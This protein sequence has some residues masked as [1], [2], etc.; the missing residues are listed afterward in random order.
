MD[1]QYPPAEATARSE[2]RLSTTS[3]MI[4]GEALPTSG[5]G[6]REA[7]AW[8]CLWRP[9]ER[10]LNGLGQL[11][12]RQKRRVELRMEGGAATVSAHTSIWGRERL[13]AEFVCPMSSLKAARLDQGQDARQAAFGVAAFA[14]GTFAG[15]WFLV[16][17]AGAGSASLAAFGALV[18][19]AGA[20]VDLARERQAAEERVS[21]FRLH[22]EWEGGPALALRVSEQEG[23]AFLNSLTRT[24][25]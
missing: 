16:R 11:L 7:F 22:L 6:W 2:E 9:A 25:G 18:V 8:L 10:I 4:A 17:G 15:T 14:C 24:L 23:R 13:T 3:L 1:P 20:A 21:P 5:R 12:L 19:L